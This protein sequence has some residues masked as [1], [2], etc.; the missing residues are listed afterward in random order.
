M[1]WFRQCLLRECVIRYFLELRSTTKLVFQF[2]TP[3]QYL[4]PGRS[5]SVDYLIPSRLL[6]ILYIS[7]K[8]FLK[9][10]DLF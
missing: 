7:I 6:Q 9:R 10:H 1:H 3:R 5:I 2:G 4:T 8:I